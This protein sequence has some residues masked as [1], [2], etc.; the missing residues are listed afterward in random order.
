MLSECPEDFKHLL[1]YF[2][3]ASELK[4]RE[5]VIAYYCGY[6]AVSVALCKPYPKSPEND[7]FIKALFDELEQ[8]NNY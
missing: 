5:P 7:A 3:R 4:T 8:V 6:Y 1:P 2:Q